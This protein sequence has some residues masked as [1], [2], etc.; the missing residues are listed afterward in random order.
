MAQG[1]P[2][3]LTWHWYTQHSLDIL[4]PQPSRVPLY[5]TVKD[6]C[7]YFARCVLLYIYRWVGLCVWGMDGSY[8]M[9]IRALLYITGKSLPALICVYQRCLGISSLLVVSLLLVLC[10]MIILLP[11]ILYAICQA[12]YLVWR[13]SSCVLYLS[14]SH[15]YSRQQVY[16][17]RTYIS[18]WINNEAQRRAVPTP[19][20]QKAGECAGGCVENFHGEWMFAVH[21]TSR[22]PCSC[23]FARYRSEEKCIEYYTRHIEEKSFLCANKTTTGWTAPGP[24]DWEKILV[25]VFSFFHTSFLLNIS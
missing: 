23:C 15:V 18:F 24:R 14:A 19:E 5:A 25:L 7:R 6:H 8:I 20:T 17:P 10:C 4:S 3:Q 13:Q 21:N 11:F 12:I 1:L 2:L 9:L 22:R 16:Q